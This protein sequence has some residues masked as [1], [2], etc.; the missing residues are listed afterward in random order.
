MGCDSPSILDAV[1]AATVLRGTRLRLRST[2][3]MYCSTLTSSALALEVR[4]YLDAKIVP[5]LT[6]C[7]SHPRKESPPWPIRTPSVC[8]APPRASGPIPRPLTLCRRGIGPPTVCGCPVGR[9]VDQS[10]LRMRRFDHSAACVRTLE[11]TCMREA[12]LQSHVPHIC[13]RTHARAR[14]CVR[15][16]VRCWRHALH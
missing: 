7:T 15:T 8:W 12:P 5:V 11:V 9:T 3:L 13:L 2:L 10:M 14:A 16:A 6:R 1:C 4:S